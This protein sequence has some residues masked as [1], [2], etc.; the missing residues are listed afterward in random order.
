[1]KKV[2]NGIVLENRFEHN[3][4]KCIS[5]LTKMGTRC[6]YVGVP[7]THSLYG[8]S[9][10]DY[11]DI[12]KADI[13]DRQISGVFPLLAACLDKDERIN[14]DAYFQVH[15]GITYAGDELNKWLELEDLDLWWFGFDCGHY[16][17]K[18]DFS[19]AYMHFPENK[20]RL[21]SLQN[22]EKDFDECFDGREVRTILYVMSECKSLA[23]QLKEYEKTKR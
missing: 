22:I 7:K 23:D 18:P 3:G 20:E 17:D 4:Y 19:A 14:I 5:T 2:I 15:G 8:K 16:N 13:A 9:V 10:R 1:M 21:E 6:G 11:L 12:K